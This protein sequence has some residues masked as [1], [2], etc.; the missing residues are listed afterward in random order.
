[1]MRL[2]VFNGPLRVRFARQPQSARILALTFNG[3]IAS[4]IPLTK[5]EEFGP[6]FGETTIGNGDPVL[7]MDVVKGDITISV[8][9]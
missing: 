3:A 8:G 6:R 7:N 9:K 1:M 5:K 4:D 2:R